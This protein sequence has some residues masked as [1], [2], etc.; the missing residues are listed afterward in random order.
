[1][2]PTPHYTLDRA[3]YRQPTHVLNLPAGWTCPW[4]SA[5][6]TKADRDTGK[7]IARPDRDENNATV[8]ELAGVDTYVCYAARSERFPSV[9]DMRWRNFDIMKALVWNWDEIPL[10]AGATHVRIHGSGDFYS[11]DYFDLWLDTCRANPDVTFWAFT[12]SLRYW[13]AR[14]SE[15][16]P[17]LALTAST[18]G[19]DDHLI[20]EHG[21]R[22]AT[23]YYDIADVPEDMMIDLD[24]WEAQMPD[25]P[26]FALL[27]NMTNRK[28]LEDERIR[29][30]NE[31]AAA[32]LT[33][34]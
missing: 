8:T 30:H 15:I 31:R 27:E 10:P 29:E 9:R 21:L 24:D 32:L 28:Q 6:L 19:K 5:C 23:V 34:D 33:A 18:G 25:H 14:L 20:A 13:V 7:I 4:A 3:Y 2:V 22:T 17:N 12:K 11:Q 26:S 16:P 1:M